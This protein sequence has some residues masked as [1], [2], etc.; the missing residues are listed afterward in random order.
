[1]TPGIAFIGLGIM[2][3]RMLTNMTAH[4]G[5]ALVGGWDPSPEAQSRTRAAFPGLEI[6]GS[7]E[8]LIRDSRTEVVYIACPPAAHKEH[9]MTAIAAGKPVFCEKPLGV[10]VAESRALVAQ[11]ETTGTRS[12]VNFPFADS[13]AVNQIDRD[14]RAGVLGDIAG[15]QIMRSRHPE[16]RQI[17]HA[18]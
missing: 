14:I 13:Q 12:A 6:W 10:D 4:G 5:F 16:R 18:A 15:V 9:A 2:G 7:A 8:A 3:H 17:M 11:A 1:M